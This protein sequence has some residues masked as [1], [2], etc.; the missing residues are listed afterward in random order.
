MRHVNMTHSRWG[1]LGLLWALLAGAFFIIIV[2]A[3]YG[4]FV[5]NDFGDLLQKIRGTGL[6]WIIGLLELFA[7]VGTVV[8]LFI[9]TFRLHR[10][11]SRDAALGWCIILSIFCL[12]VFFMKIFT[13]GF[14]IFKEGI[15]YHSLIFSAIEEYML[16]FVLM[17]A[18]VVSLAAYAR[19]SW[20]RIIFTLFSGT[21][22]WTLGFGAYSLLNYL[23]MGS[24]SWAGPVAVFV[25]VFGIYFFRPV[26]TRRKSLGK[27]F[28]RL[29]DLRKAAKSQHKKMDLSHIEQKFE[30]AKKS[31]M[32]ASF[33]GVGYERAMNKMNDA[34]QAVYD[35]VSGRFSSLDNTTI[36][37]IEAFGNVRS[38]RA[39]S[40]KLN[41]I[42]DDIRK[43]EDA[44][45]DGA[46][47]KARD[48]ASELRRN[49][50]DLRELF[51][52]SKDFLDKA[53][54]AVER[55]H[56]L[57]A[58]DDEAEHKY[59]E[60]KK[61]FSKGKYRRAGEEA[62]FAFEEGGGTADVF[63]KARN[64]IEK[65]ENRLDNKADHRM[66]TADIEKILDKAR[67]MLRGVSN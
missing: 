5:T 19:S 61:S 35:A 14:S 6:V 48:V 51:D 24:I 17:V 39:D 9:L 41:D 23:E 20:T 22:I 10:K 47:D 13:R 64:L 7:V 62:R 28:K 44:L 45:E 1:L 65:L 18:L 37:I 16:I 42:E 67:R 60:A 50:K 30:E 4:T 12:I 8:G 49:A 15:I 59:D 29:K 58:A 27:E 55:L 21:L 26:S 46:L 38:L 11:K 32:L 25:V 34:F 56:K 3:I 53:S 36:P 63:E 54:G 57:G 33:T 43:L 66:Y 52:S 2:Y 40:A 31:K